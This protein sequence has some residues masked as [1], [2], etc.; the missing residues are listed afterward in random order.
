LVSDKKA[1]EIH[2][3]RVRGRAAN[4]IIQILDD[5]VSEEVAGDNGPCFNA[6]S[7]ERVHD[8]PPSLSDFQTK[9]MGYW[10]NIRIQ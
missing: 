6:R 2:P 8:L 5:R 1:V 4:A 7:L 9:L 3:L 10:E